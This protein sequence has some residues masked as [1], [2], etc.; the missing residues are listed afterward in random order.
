MKKSRLDK[1]KDLKEV[2][3]GKTKDKAFKDLKAK[4]KDELLETMAKM[5]GLID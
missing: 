2:Q 4:D 1:L 5:L 3:K